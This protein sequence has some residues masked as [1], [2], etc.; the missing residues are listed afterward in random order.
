[1]LGAYTST[2]HLPLSVDERGQLL[3]PKGGV[4]TQPLTVESIASGGDGHLWYVTNEGNS[5][6]GLV[7][8]ITLRRTLFN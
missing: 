5:K 2:S 4:S 3:V 8:L 6:V 7:A 1:M